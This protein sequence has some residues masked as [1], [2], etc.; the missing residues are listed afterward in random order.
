MTDFAEKR[1]G[2]L[3]IRIDRRLCVGFG[4][5]IEAA[6][7]LFE[8]D[9][10]GIAAFKDDLTPDEAC[11]LEACRVCPVDALIA[12]DEAGIQVAP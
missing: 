1:I 8:L 11:A 5:C 10:D 12:L 2:R 4:D 9:D 7:D 3:V 6:G